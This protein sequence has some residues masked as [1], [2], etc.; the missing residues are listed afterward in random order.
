MT[1][2]S[3]KQRRWFFANK[4]K[5]DYQTANYYSKNTGWIYTIGLK[6]INDGVMP[7][8]IAESDLDLWLEK[9]GW[10]SFR[11]YKNDLENLPPAISWLA[12]IK[13]TVL[14]ANILAF[15]SLFGAIGNT[16]KIA[17]VKVA[18]SFKTEILE[19]MREPAFRSNKI[20]GNLVRTVIKA[21]EKGITNIG[22]IIAKFEPYLSDARGLAHWAFTRAT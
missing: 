16:S 4:Y 19:F 17:S 1:F 21:R 8:D 11:E 2:V 9:N 18:R 20:R 13:T 7:A 10:Q 22:P 14:L 6:E 3:E 5:K 12:D 15:L